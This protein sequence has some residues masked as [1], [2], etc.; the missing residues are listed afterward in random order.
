MGK[1]FQIVKYEGFGKGVS[2][3]GNA[4]KWY[5]SRGPYVKQKIHDYEMLLY[6]NDTGISR[7]LFIVQDRERE[8]RYILD[9]ILKPG[10]NI[11]DLGA[12][13]GYYTIMM[14]KKGASKIY[15]IEP[16]SKNFLLLAK[17]VQ[18]N[19]LNNVELEM[20]AASDNNGTAKFYLSNKSNVNTMN[21]AGDHLTGKYVTIETVKTSDYIKGK[22]IDLIRM[23]IEGHEVNV[24]NDLRTSKELPEYILFEVHP[25]KYNK[26]N[27]L[28][29]AL[30]NLLPQGYIVDSY[31]LEGQKT[32]KN[33]EI[34]IISDG[35]IRRIYKGYPL[36]K[37]FK[38]MR[39]ILLR[40]TGG[41]K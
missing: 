25:N 37:D 29:K 27:S 33:A 35:E 9:K 22:N 5:T 31:V 2:M 8:H 32:D 13:I 10:M 19:E 30:A 23:D 1:F 36:V 40:R 6:R 26:D 7:S 39:V 16:D 3:M 18:L 15:A 38:N 14:S 28:N 11:L 21:P 20:V 17:N 41:Q 4:L 24:L 34:N 12:N